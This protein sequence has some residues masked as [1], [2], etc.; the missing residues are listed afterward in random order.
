MNPHTSASPQ[1]VPEKPTPEAEGTDVN[2]RGVLIFVGVML[3]SALIIHVAL[4]FMELHFK[5][6]EL[7]EKGLRSQDQ[8][9]SAV[10]RGVP[11]FP[12]PRLQLSPPADM[13]NFRAKEEAELT[14]YGWIDKNSGLVR[15]PI[16]RAMEIVAKQG[17]PAG[18]TNTGEKGKSALDMIRDRAQKK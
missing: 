4:Y 10:A 6:R 17:L 2:I 18:N 14:S 7:K 12:E 1:G 9:R 15:I 5:H 16:Q 8:I 13:A 11:T 3:V